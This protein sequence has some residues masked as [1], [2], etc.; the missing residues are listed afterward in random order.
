MTEDKMVGWHH[1]L[2]GHESEQT[3][4]DSGQRSLICSSPWVRK[5]LDTTEGVN[6]NKQVLDCKQMTPGF[7]QG[8]RKEVLGSTV[9]RSHPREPSQMTVAWGGGRGAE[10]TPALL[11]QQGPHVLAHS[12]RDTSPHCPCGQD[13]RQHDLLF[14]PLRSKSHLS[15]LLMSSYLFVELM[16]GRQRG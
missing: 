10:R 5:E 13:R 9:S 7:P 4:G 16:G 15:R 6:N 8:P 1:R 3:P 11:C 12:G 14:D 2:N